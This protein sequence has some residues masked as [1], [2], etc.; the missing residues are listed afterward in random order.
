MS[1]LRLIAHNI[2]DNI[3]DEKLFFLVG[4]LKNLQGFASQEVEPDKFDLELIADGK[5]D[6]DGGVF[7]E[8]FVK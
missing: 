6:N 2:I 3:P 7:I 5:I 8:D 4:L 1:E